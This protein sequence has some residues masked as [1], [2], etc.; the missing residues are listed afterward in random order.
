MF[1]D[2]LPGSTFGFAHFRIPILAA[3]TFA[4]TFR[5]PKGNAGLWVSGEWLAAA[6]LIPSFLACVASPYIF[7]DSPT[8]ARPPKVQRDRIVGSLNSWV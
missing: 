8:H 7:F 3:R 6:R 4:T 5:M 2:M 1:G